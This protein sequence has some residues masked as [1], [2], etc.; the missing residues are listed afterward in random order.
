MRHR[1][2]GNALGRTQSERKALLRGLA[3]SLINYGKVRTT[4]AKARALRPFV[5]PLVTRAKSDTV[6]NRRLI[7][8]RIANPAAVKKLFAEVGPR[9]AERKGGYTRLI[10]ISGLRRGDAA[11]VAEV[12]WV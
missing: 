3:L 6:A 11:Q 10:K 4:E 9:F 5:E 7:A 12:Q 1:V 2:R 8:A